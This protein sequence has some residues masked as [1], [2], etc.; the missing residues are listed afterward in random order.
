MCASTRQLMMDR[1]DTQIAFQTFEGRFDLGQL[2]VAI[3]QYGRILR[4]QVRPQQ[5][6]TVTHFGLF[7]PGLVELKRKRFFRHF[8]IRLRQIDFHES[9]SSPS[10]GFGGAHAHQQLIPLRTAPPHGAHLPQ[11][12]RQLLPPHRHLFRLPSFTFRQHVQLTALRK[13]LHFHRFAN[14]MPGQF[15]P[16][17]FILLDLRPRRAHQIKR[18]LPRRS[19]LLQERLGRD[20]PIH[21]PNPPRFAVQAFDAVQK[22]A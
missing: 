13:Q 17:F 18:L 15:Q 4:H 2:H 19:H 1:P 20:S 12:P 9:E 3:P 10:I 6:V 5:I 21:Q 7:Q 11:E 22:A 8:L 16:S 14:L